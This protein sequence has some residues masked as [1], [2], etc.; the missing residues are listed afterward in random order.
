[1]GKEEQRFVV[2]FFWLK[3]RGLKNIYQELTT[4]LEDDAYG[5]LRSKSGCRGS[6][7]G[8]FHAVTFLVG[9]DHPS[10]WDRRSRHFSKKVLSQVPA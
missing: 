3:G 10:L 9:D 8:V 7:P 6:E 5:L 2:K 4:T 1:M